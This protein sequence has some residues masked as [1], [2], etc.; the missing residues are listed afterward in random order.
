V[1]LPILLQISNDE[2]LTEARQLWEKRSISVREDY[3]TLD[4]RCH[5]SSWHS[6]HLWVIDVCC[7]GR[8]KT[9]DAAPRAS[10]RAPSVGTWTR[11]VSSGQL[12]YIRRCLHRS[13]FMCMALYPHRQAHSGSPGRDVYPPA[14]CWSIKLIIIG[15]VP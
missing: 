8:S 5:V 11:S 4:V 15:S 2:T 3:G 6:T 12:I 10:T 14:V 1:F 9:E 7:R 13:G